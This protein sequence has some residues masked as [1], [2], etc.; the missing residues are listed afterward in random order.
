[1]FESK[2]KLSVM[3]PLDKGDLPELDTSEH[4]DQEVMQKFQ[5]LTGAIQ[6]AVSLGRLDVNT[7][8]VNPVLFRA[9]PRQ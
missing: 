2:P 1:M 4:L 9:E 5:S 3:S 7:V 8:V 6:C